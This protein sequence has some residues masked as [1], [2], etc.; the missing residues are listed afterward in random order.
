MTDT[1]DRRVGRSFFGAVAALRQ[2]QEA[3]IPL[4]LGGHDVLIIA[5]TGAGKTEAAVAPLVQRYLASR[6]ESGGPDVLY[7][8]PTRALVNDLVLRLALPLENL[9]LRVGARHGERDDL[10]RQMPPHLLVITLE[11]YDNVLTTRPLLLDQAR[12]VVVDEVHQL[13]DTQ[14]GLQLRHVL[15]RHEHRLQS[16]LQVVAMSATVS[17]PGRVW[18]RI[19]PARTPRIVRSADAR[20][21]AYVVARA[22]N[23]DRLR[24]LMERTH[25]AGKVLSFA[26]SRRSTEELASL[27]RG[28]PFGERV[29]VHHSSLAAAE[30]LAVEEE[31]RRSEPALIAATSTLELGIDVGDVGLVALVGAPTDWKSFSQRLGRANRRAD[32]VKVLCAVPPW[33]EQPVRELATF[34]ALISQL[35]SPDGNARLSGGSGRLVGASLQQ[36][37]NQ[38]RQAGASEWQTADQLTAALGLESIA[39]TLQLLVALEEHGLATRHPVKA[40]LWARGP[41]LEQLERTGDLWGNFPVSSSSLRLLHHMRV[42]GEVPGVNHLRLTVGATFAF[43]G[44]VWRVDRIAR[45]EAHL[46]PSESVPS[47]KLVFTS[48]APGLSAALVAALPAAVR[49]AP[50]AAVRM[51]P[52]TSSWWDQ[53]QRHLGAALPADGLPLWR[54]QG[55]WALGTFAGR[56]VNAAALELLGLEGTYDDIAIRT[57]APIDPSTLPAALVEWRDAV[58]AVVQVPGELTT[59]QQRLPCDLLEQELTEAVMSDPATAVAISRVVNLPLLSC[60]DDRLE[61][62]CQSS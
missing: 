7:V 46:L 55:R 9:G 45:G 23:E 27:L 17:D 54:H 52:A 38:L 21:R 20:T 18:R 32:Q 28:G 36:L 42:L 53:V 5:G 6:D 12:A 16:A 33:I 26:G 40:S 30:R 1:L 50:P 35:E 8:A 22:E 4:I 13:A 11:S 3:S 61:A 48:V 59:W 37:V 15:S 39:S 43:R 41:E 49:E 56:T 44:R 47:V 34:L 29:L 24:A 2:A 58:A 62:L 31:F 10:S 14:R 19:R 60:E 51:P 25:A 57:S